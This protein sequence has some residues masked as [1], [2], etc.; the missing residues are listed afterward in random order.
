[1]HK[2]TCFEEV[3]ERTNKMFSA[4]QTWHWNERKTEVNF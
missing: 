2:F 3:I 4:C 1:M